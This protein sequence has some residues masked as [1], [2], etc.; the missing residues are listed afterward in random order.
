[1]LNISY[2][3]CRCSVVIIILLAIITCKSYA[4]TASEAQTQV[5]YALGHTLIWAS[6]GK[7]QSC[8]RDAVTLDGV[9][10]SASV[11]NQTGILIKYI[12]KDFSG[13]QSGPPAL[14]MSDAQSRAVTFMQNVGVSLIDPWSQTTATYLDHGSGWREYAFSWRKI[15]Q[16]VRLPA[17]IDVA[18]D[19]DSGEVRSYMLID[20]AVTIP[21]I[22]GIT[23]NNAVAAVALNQNIAN[24]VVQSA[25][26]T[27]WYHPV[28]FDYT[29]SQPGV[30]TLY[31]EV[32]IHN[33]NAMV[34]STSTIV[35]RIDANTGSIETILETPAISQH[36]S[37]AFPK[38]KHIAGDSNSKRKPNT[39]VF[40]K[41][42]RSSVNISALRYAKLPPTVFQ[43]AARKKA[44]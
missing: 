23:A 35:A 43:A 40:I 2:L 5:A 7:A 42:L 41:T 20:D 44:K 25:L 38:K 27:V 28:Y 19:A 13:T 18:I 10:A 26:L 30:Q 14:A 31:W 29:T 36:Q 32:T 12:S 39:H 15:V 8:H 1:M 17:S 24:P 9:S 37:F 33:P 4:L 21:L 16:G 22:P 6:V 34:G 11:D 3:H